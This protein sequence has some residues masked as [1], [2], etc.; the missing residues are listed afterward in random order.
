MG[1]TRKSLILD[2]SGHLVTDKHSSL[3]CPF[4]SDKEYGRWLQEKEF[5]KIDS[6]L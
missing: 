3:I 6:M 1:P 4:V 5:N 2:Y